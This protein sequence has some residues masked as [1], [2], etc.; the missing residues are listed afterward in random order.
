MT[1]EQKNQAYEIGVRLVERIGVSAAILAAFLWL[2]REAATS[3]H[4]SV[5]VPIVKSHTEFLDTTSKTLVELS[6][7]QRQQ[8]E[9]LQELAIG[10]RDIHKVLSEGTG[11]Q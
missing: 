3:L 2:A 1:D 6:Q 11:K 9:T 4:S 8:S 7:T 5:V 10:Q